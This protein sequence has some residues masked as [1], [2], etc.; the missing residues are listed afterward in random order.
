MGIEA[1]GLYSPASIVGPLAQVAIFSRYHSQQQLNAYFAAKLEIYR[2][3]TADQR[4]GN[5]IDYSQWRGLRLRQPVQ[6]FL[7]AVNAAATT[8]PP[9][10]DA[11]DPGL[12]QRV[13]ALATTYLGTLPDG[14]TG[15]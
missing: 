7:A 8:W 3:F 10:A 2:R 12:T 1:P 13:Q 9:A 5:V 14:A 15:S 11:S 4:I 6:D